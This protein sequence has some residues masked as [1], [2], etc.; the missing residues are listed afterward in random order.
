MDELFQQIRV[1]LNTKAITL[2]NEVKVWQIIVFV[3]P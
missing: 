3:E 2:D 1:F